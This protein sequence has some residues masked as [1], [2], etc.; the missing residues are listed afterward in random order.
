MS[1]IRIDKGFISGY[2]KDD[3]SLVA[4]VRLTK[5]GVFPYLHS[6]GRIIKEAKLPEE[7]LKIPQYNLPMAQW[8]LIHT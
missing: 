1:S 7:L 8:S 3:G 2:R 6:D 5:T 4:N